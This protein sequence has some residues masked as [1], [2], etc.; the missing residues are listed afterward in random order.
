MVVH[1]APPPGVAPWWCGGGGRPA[2][3][4][5]FGTEGVLPSSA[6]VPVGGMC[7][8]LDWQLLKPKLAARG[9]KMAVA[10]E[11][12]GLASRHG[13]GTTTTR[14]R[15]WGIRNRAFSTQN[16]ESVVVKQVRFGRTNCETPE[17]V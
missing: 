5:K 15:C 14:Q 2:F 10:G 17:A 1:L 12:A 8:L 11:L 16:R 13:V 9:G 4:A 7:W 3:G 6:T